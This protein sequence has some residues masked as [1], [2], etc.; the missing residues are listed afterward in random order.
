MGVTHDPHAG[1]TGG[2]GNPD[3]PD[4]IPPSAEY[5]DLGQWARHYSIVRMTLGTFWLGFPLLVLQQ[6][7]STPDSLMLVVVLS[8]TVFGFCLFALFTA[9]AVQFSVRQLN[10]LDGVTE[11]VSVSEGFRRSWRRPDGIWPG[12]LAY[13][14]V[15]LIALMWSATART[16]FDTSAR[17]DAPAADTVAVEPARQ[18]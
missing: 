7:W 13:A 18:R 4:R 10:K 15:V 8:M 9:K 14:G 12:L 11:T 17:G 5:A 16:S 2:N 1:N 6:Q 3:V